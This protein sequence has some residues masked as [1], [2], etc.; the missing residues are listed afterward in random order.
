[1]TVAKLMGCESKT[2][3]R[4]KD[5]FY[6][7]PPWVTEQLCAVEQIPRT[8]WEPSSGHGAITRVLQRHGVEVVETDLV[9]R[10][11]QRQLNFLAAREALVRAI[12]TNPPFN[13]ANQY[14]RQAHK[15]GVGYVAMLLK[16]G[17]LS[18]LSRTSAIQRACGHW[19][20]ARTFLVK[21]RPVW[22]A[23]GLFGTVGMLRTPSPR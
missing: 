9:S 11:G 19:P 21:V 4:K 13:I 7:T 20:I 3:T 12:V 5:D 16:I 22:I 23:L 2:N 15:L 6:E 14:V 17:F 10:V 1:M 18:T 8:V